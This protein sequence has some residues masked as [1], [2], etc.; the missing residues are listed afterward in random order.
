[1]GIPCEVK[2]ILKLKPSQGCPTLIENGKR[3]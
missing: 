3:Y 1:M 2:S